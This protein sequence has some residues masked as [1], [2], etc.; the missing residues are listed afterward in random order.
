MMF[1][2]TEAALKAL[3]K[4]RIDAAHPEGEA[5]RLIKEG[6]GFGFK[7]GAARLTDMV[8]QHEGQDVLLVA[9]VLNRT[10]GHMR[11]DTVT[12]NGKNTFVLN[13]Q[14]SSK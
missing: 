1:Q 9:S 11:L 6:D 2:V 13:E 10:M 5:M 12:R 8:F 14:P 7:L 4:G 3:Y